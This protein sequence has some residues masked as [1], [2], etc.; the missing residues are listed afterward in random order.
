[1][2]MP[3]SSVVADSTL[4]LLLLKS[5]SDL[6]TEWHDPAQAGVLALVRPLHVDGQVKLAINRGTLVGL[7]TVLPSGKT[8]PATRRAV[9]AGLG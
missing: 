5:V 3:I 6:F 8:Q 9:Q 2:S 4:T 7:Q 1:M